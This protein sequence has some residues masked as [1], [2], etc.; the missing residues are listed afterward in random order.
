MSQ[1]GSLTS[2]TKTSYAYSSTNQLTQSGTSQFSYDL[3]GNIVSTGNSTLSYNQGDQLTTLSQ[4]GSSTEFTYDFNGNRISQSSSTSATITY[5]YNAN[6]QLTS[7]LNPTLSANYSHNPLGLRTTAT[8]NGVNSSFVYS[9]SNQLLTDGENYYIYG[10]SG[11]PIEQVSQ[12]TGAATYLFSDQLG[13]VVMEADQNGNVVA[14]QSYSPY[15]T[16]A[17]S[18]GTD[19]TPFGFAGGYT[20]P[21]GLIYFINRYY[22]PATGQFLSVDPAISQTQQPYSYTNG[23]PVNTAD[24]LGLSSLLC[25]EGFCRPGIN[26]PAC[27][28]PGLCGPNSPPGRS[29]RGGTGG[30]CP[31]QGNQKHRIWL[32]CSESEVGLIAVRY[33]AACHAWDS[34]GNS[35]T[36]VTTG[37]GW[38]AAIDVNATAYK[39]YACSIASLAGGFYTVSLS[40]PV[41][42]GSNSR[43]G[44]TSGSGTGGSVGIGVFWGNT[45]TEIENPSGPSWN[46]KCCT[47]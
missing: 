16:L 15:G 2:P 37:W 47:R 28:F 21:S 45:N 6:N 42:G 9:P 43:S 18:T 22:D 33:T 23:N 34:E 46:A 12:S 39:F 44:G 1:S 38:G 31:C 27:T 7:I 13:S 25:I 40:T 19:P 30:G 8:Y 17:S 4:G 3:A 35:A 32:V 24:P 20:D 14:T 5:G 26:G 10:P 36:L 11:V 41:V 29:G